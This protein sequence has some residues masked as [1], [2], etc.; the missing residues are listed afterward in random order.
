M[1]AS[2][3]WWYTHLTPRGWEEG[4]SKID[5]VG[6]TEVPV[7]SDRVKT[8]RTSEYMSSVYSKLES[9][10]EVTWASSSPERLELEKRFGAMPHDAK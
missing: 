4:S 8:V 7:P 3:E 2:D 1:A 6:E 10:V 9:K 5:F